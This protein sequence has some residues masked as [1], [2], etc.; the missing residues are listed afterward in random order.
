MTLLERVTKVV[1][2]LIF[3]GIVKNRR[4]LAEK[5]GYTES[6]L[7]QILNG[8]VKL[9]ERFQK[10]LSIM[11]DRIN[12]EWIS[13]EKGDMIIANHSVVNENSDTNS[14]TYKPKSNA[15]PRV[16]D[17]LNVTIAPLISQYA[18]AGYLTGYADPEYLEKQ[19][20]YVAAQKYSGGNYV[21]FEIRGD[22]MD[23]DRRNAICNGDVVLGRE[24]HRDYWKC[25]LHV[26]KIFI[27]VHKEDGIILKEVVDHDIESGFITCHSFN[28]DK[29]RYPDFQLH[30]KD[31]QQLF[32]LKELRR[33]E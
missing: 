5:L 12:A 4:D 30:L 23:N 24:L 29:T 16:I 18:Q 1:E 26:P 3:D 33:G 6:S 19:P 20:L 21:A 25:K 28:P 10:K 9:S 17:E 27:I 14:H 31:I 2:W 22:S 13:I 11:D 32:Y 15:R 8:K 7:S